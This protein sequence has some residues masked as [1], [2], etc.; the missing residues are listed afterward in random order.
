M[1]LYLI[2]ELKN[3][4]NGGCLR[5]QKKWRLSTSAKEGRVWWEE[6]TMIGERQ[7]SVCDRG[8]KVG[9]IKK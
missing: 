3:K 7:L 6:V 9:T 5:V 8:R 4:G 2:V 1:T